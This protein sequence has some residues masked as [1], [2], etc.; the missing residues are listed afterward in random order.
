MRLHVGAKT[1]VGRV[2]ELNEDAYLASTDGCLFVVCDGMGGAPAGEVAS[3][4]AVRAIVQQF[5]GGAAVSDGLT[6]GDSNGYLPQTSRLGDAIRRC[7]QIVYAHAQED[8]RHSGMGTTVV[9]ACIAKDIASIAH[10]GDSRAY[11][12]HDDRLESLTRDHSLGQAQLRAGVPADSPSISEQQNVLLRVLGRAPDVD[13][14][15]TEVPVRAGDYLLLCSDGLTRMVPE[16]TIEQTILRLR[17]P[18]RIADH[19][20]EAANECGGADNTT[21]VVVEIGR[22]WWDRLS[23]RWSGLA[24]T[25]A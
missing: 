24:R 22:G 17:Q 15:L 8:P 1:D 4:L 20:I 14:E 3:D 11:L 7:N 10:V 21:I 18:Q 5:N 19:L 16:P 13:V 9:A 23:Y 2:R 25:P 12:W 6:N